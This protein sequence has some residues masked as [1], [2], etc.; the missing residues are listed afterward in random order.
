[1]FRL[2]VMPHLAVPLALVLSGCGQEVD[3]GRPDSARDFPTPDRPVATLGATQFSTEEARDDRN[4]ATTVMNMAGVRPGMTVA[5][6]GAGEG[7]Y[8]VRL[9]ERVG[10]GGRVVAQDIDEEA[11]QRLGLRVERQRLD[12]VAIKLGAE[13]DAK[14]PSNS[15]DRVFMVH[16]YHEISE[17]YA[18]IWRLAGSLKPGGQVVVVDVDRPT[19]RHGIPPDLLFC[20]FESAGYRLTEFVRKPDIQGYLAKFEVKAKRPE[21]KNIKPC[22]LS[23]K[24]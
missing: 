24:G 4:E 15:F 11:L 7:Y 3:D 8:T 18:L 5:D 16:M 22:S 10:E 2:G 12:N 9:A 19:N 6:I 17:P 1:M 23:V 21:P 14:L 20:E 13:D